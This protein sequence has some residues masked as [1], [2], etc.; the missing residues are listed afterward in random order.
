MCM[1]YE[2]VNETSSQ[3]RKKALI[4]LS[5]SCGSTKVFDANTGFIDLTVSREGQRV[6][7]GKLLYY[8]ALVKF[9][10]TEPAH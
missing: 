10:C 4:L 7:F 1:Y 3:S 6:P 9:T 5:N 2:A 8:S